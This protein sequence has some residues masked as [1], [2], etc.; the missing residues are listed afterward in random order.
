M[1]G[2]KIV[3]NITY[4]DD[5][6]LLAESMEDLQGLV[7][8]VND[9]CTRYGLTI[10]TT[11]IKLMVVSRDIVPTKIKIRG[12]DIERVNHFKYLGA[13]LNDQVKTQTKKSER[14]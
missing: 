9:A 6:A 5:M 10:N 8:A 1:I 2:G 4:A 13:W 11:K 14:G 3:S 7:D 12:E